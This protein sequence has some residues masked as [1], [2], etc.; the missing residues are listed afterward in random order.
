VRW[1][2]TKR[3]AVAAALKQLADVSAK[4]AGVVLNQVDM[5]KQASYAY[6]DAG[7]YYSQYGKCYAE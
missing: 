6:G 5:K 3:D 7:Q 2:R 4:M 1:D